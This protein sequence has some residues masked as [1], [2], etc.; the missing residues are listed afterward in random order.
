MGPGPRRLSPWLVLMIAAACQAADWPQY[1]ADGART[2]YTAEKLPDVLHLQW[3]YKL[4]H[5]PMP[6]WPDPGWERN[7]LAFDCADHAVA[8]GGQV[9]F[10]SSAD[11]AVRALDAVTGQLRW[12]FLTG[13]PVR[14]APAV[15]KDRLFV[16]SDDGCLYCLATASGKLLW[17]HYGGPRRQSIV[18]NGRIVSRWPA[19]GGPVVA[20][21]VVYYS[22]GIFPTQG[23]FLY[24]ID[25]VSG[26]VVW[27]NDTACLSYQNINMP[28]GNSFTGVAAQG[29]LVALGDKLLAPTGRGLPGVF[30][31]A[32]GALDYYGNTSTFRAGG[33]WVMSFD[34]YFVCADKAYDMAD[35]RVL[36]T[37]LGNLDRSFG[38]AD[39]HALQRYVPPGHM[40]RELAVTPNWLLVATGDAVKMAKRSEPFKAGPGP[41]PR[42]DDYLG[43]EEVARLQQVASV[44]A[45]DA[46][47][48][49]GLI[50]AGETAYAGGL[51]KVSALDLSQQR[52]VWSAEVDGTAY[53]LA[54][55]NGSLL[56][57]T[58]KGAL[59]CFAPQSGGGPRTNVE[60]PAR[61]P[62]PDEDP[63]AVRVAEAIVA[64]SGVREGYCFDLGCGDGRLAYE[65][66]RRTDLYVYAVDSDPKNVQAAREALQ[67]RGLRNSRLG[68]TGPVVGGHGGARLFRGT[69]GLR[70]VGEG[71][72]RGSSARRGD[73][74]RPA[75]RGHRSA[76]P[77]GRYGNGSPRAAGR[78]RP[79][80][81]PIR[82]CGQQPVLR[83]CRGQKS[84]GG[85]LVR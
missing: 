42:A 84:A 21:D 20:G 41:N 44:G 70:A 57:T 12:K 33:S 53:G 32:T 9:F 2:G 64:R 77:A 25:P 81:S 37:D 8:A 83:R 50:A 67:R 58:S 63:P 73:A 10:G 69:R 30:H 14:F 39:K 27:V 28:S 74:S 72:S 15:W 59:Y 66:A 35:G 6:A 1:R 52:V 51:G 48:Q 29:Y 46:P 4:L 17:S 47:S 3:S 65:L 5:A 26:K 11:C 45:V 7:R 43:P 31:R 55:A 54:V 71:R 34:T 82:R 56:V 75:L 23:A 76:G 49:G 13:G 40:A 78:R 22:V 61:D 79:L 24:A 16:A 85:S 19:R 18:G 36:C 68:R 80:E 38:T 60:Q 62:Y